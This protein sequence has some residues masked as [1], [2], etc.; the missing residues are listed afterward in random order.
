MSGGKKAL[1]SVIPTNKVYCNNINW[2]CSLHFLFLFAQ[3]KVA[4][5]S[6]K[7]ESTK[8]FVVLSSQEI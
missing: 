3:N 7:I 2:K 4:A 5:S 6:E 8:L 1:L